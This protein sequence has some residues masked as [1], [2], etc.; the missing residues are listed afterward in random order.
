MISYIRYSANDIELTVPDQAKVIQINTSHFT[1]IE[2][3][4][5]LCGFSLPLLR[6][7][8]KQQLHNVVQELY[9]GICGCHINN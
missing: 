3:Y 8:I 2:D 1:M 7:L 5:F 4:L 6:Y 9:E